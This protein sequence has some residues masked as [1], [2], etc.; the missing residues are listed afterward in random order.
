MSQRETLTTTTVFGTTLLAWAV[1]IREMQGMNA[2][3]GTSLGSFAWFLGIWATMTVA[4]MLPGATP[5]AVLF[6]R[7]HGGLETFAFLVGQLVVWTA[8][9]AAAYSIDLA[10]RQQAPSFV[11]WDN[12]GPWLA[13]AALAGA[14]VYQ[15]T[16]L[17]AACLRF[18]RSP[19]HILMRTRPGLL[20]AARSGC[21]SGVYCVGCC[22]GLMLAL[23]A[24]GVMS[25]FWMAIIAAAISAEKVLRRG[26]AIAAAL[27]ILLAV[28]GAWV[29]LLPRTVPGLQ[30]PKPMQPMPIQQGMSR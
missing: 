25:L 27:A 28:L 5:G 8:C 26:K 16:P 3:P 15:L 1:A 10:V 6:S 9:G 20:P 29:A 4:M 22:S 12:R 14:G 18:C 30:Q 2:G 21:T 7:F 13:G 23:F 17:K 24:L 19:L 11:A